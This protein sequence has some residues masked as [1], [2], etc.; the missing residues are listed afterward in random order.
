MPA[1]VVTQSVCAR[2]HAQRGSTASSVGH[3]VMMGDGV[4]WLRCLPRG[5]LFGGPDAA[6][7]V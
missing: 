1:C 3:G 2:A 5:P 4:G 7:R 6:M